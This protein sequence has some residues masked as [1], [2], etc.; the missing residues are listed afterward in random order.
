MQGP[1]SA[2]SVHG[3]FMWDVRKGAMDVPEW[4]NGGIMERSCKVHVDSL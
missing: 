1:W 2:W 3:M 4:G